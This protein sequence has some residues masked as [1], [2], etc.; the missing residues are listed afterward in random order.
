MTSV[1]VKSLG[2]LQQLVLSGEQ[3]FIGDSDNHGD[4]QVGPGPYQMLL[5]SIAT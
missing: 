2:K 1:T 4:D 3:F 5:A